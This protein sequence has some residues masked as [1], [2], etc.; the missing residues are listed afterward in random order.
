MACMLSQPMLAERVGLFRWTAVFGFAGVIIAIRPFDESFLG[1][2]IVAWQCILLAL[3]ALLTRKYA[4]Q[5]S[6][7]VMQF[8]SGAV[9]TICLLPFAILSWRSCIFNNWVIMVSLGIFGWAGHRQQRRLTALRDLYS[10]A[11]R[12][13]LHPVSDHLVISD[14]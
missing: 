8:Y 2:L 13:F 4:G 9:G 11:V 12:I 14:F 6:T 10:D 3:Y 1:N 5:V 7:D